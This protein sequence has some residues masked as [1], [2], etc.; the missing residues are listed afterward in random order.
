MHFEISHVTNA[1][2]LIEVIEVVRLQTLTFRGMAVY[3]FWKVVTLKYLILIN[4]LVLHFTAVSYSF[5][6]VCSG[7]SGSSEEAIFLFTDCYTSSVEETLWE[8]AFICS[9]WF[10]CVRSLSHLAFVLAGSGVKFGSY[11]I[12]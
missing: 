6:W 4:G 5:F 7:K 8:L 1:K 12:S 9:S 2:C 11:Q 3:P 10:F